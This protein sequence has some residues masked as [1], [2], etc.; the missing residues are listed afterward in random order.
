MQTQNCALIKCTVWPRNDIVQDNSRI[1]PY[2]F[3]EWKR[4]QIQIR[5]KFFARLNASMTA[6]C[7]TSI[8]A[9]VTRQFSIALEWLRIK[10]ASTFLLA[11]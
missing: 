9:S 4:A 8:P 6:S 10:N 3:G 5:F 1:K 2:A 11:P 7:I